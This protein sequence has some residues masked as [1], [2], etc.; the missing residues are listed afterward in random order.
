[1][2]L[3]ESL[4]SSRDP[5]AEAQRWCSQLPN[6]NRVNC[7][8]VVGGGKG[9]HLAELRRQFQGKICVFEPRLELH[10]LYN[11]SQFEIHSEIKNISELQ[12]QVD[13]V[14]EFRPCWGS[15]KNE[16]AKVANDLIGPD[17]K[18][19]AQENFRAVPEKWRSHLDLLL[20]IIK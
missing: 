8:F 3:N 1:M 12:C 18:T 15:L 19:L 16:F 14:A 9:F 20:E 10:K 4:C 17:I 5:I 6:L 2:S 13:L 11:L 7:I